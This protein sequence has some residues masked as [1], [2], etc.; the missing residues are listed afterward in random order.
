MKEMI[1]E[2]TTIDPAELARRTGWELKP[3][4]ACKGDRCVPLGTGRVSAELLA[5]RLGMGLARDER[6]GLMALGPDADGPALAC[7]ELPDITLP[8]RLGKPFSLRS[9]RGSKVFLLVWASW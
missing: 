6:R 9:L 5:D 7:A 1:V 2:G 8:D 3:E 4:G